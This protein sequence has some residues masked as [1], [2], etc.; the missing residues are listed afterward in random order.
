MFRKGSYDKIRVV[1]SIAASLTSQH[2]GCWMTVF[3]LVRTPA[4]KSHKQPQKNVAD[5]IS[6]F[7]KTPEKISIEAATDTA[8]FNCSQC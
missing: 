5:K 1:G 8:T 2:G 3:R 6:M 7:A 4:N